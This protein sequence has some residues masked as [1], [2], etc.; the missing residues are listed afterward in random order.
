MIDAGIFEGDIVVVNTKKP[1]KNGDIVVALIDNANTIK[2]YI[3][4]GGK[5]YL[6]AENTIYGVYD[7]I[8]TVYPRASGMARGA[9]RGVF[10]FYHKWLPIAL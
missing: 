3:K 6:K 7:G 8:F 10:G 5:V 2:R 9:W 1:A 4:E